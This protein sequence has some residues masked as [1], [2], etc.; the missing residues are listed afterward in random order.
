MATGRKTATVGMVGLRTDGKW[1][2]SQHPLG[3]LSHGRAETI[4][5]LEEENFSNISV[6]FGLGQ[7]VLLDELTISCR[8]T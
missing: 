7:Y 4:N 6:L 3:A 2:T 8:V 5:D 1:Y